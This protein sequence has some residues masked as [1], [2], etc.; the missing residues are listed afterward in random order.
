MSS[1]RRIITGLFF[2]CLMVSSA[3]AQTPQVIPFSSAQPV[4]NTYLKT[5][6]PALKPNGQPTAAAWD[7]WARSNDQEIRTRMER[8]EEDTLTNLLRLGV[9][10]TKEARID[11]A[12]LMRY[13]HDSNRRFAGRQARRR[14]DPRPRRTACQ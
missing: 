14:S 8:G 12:D 2:V 9:T 7:A 3:V 1:H 6:P 4:L 11:Y 10:Y 5:L 13:G